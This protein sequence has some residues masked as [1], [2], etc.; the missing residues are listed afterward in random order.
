MSLN[1]FDKRWIQSDK[2]P[3]GVTLPMLKLNEQQFVFTSYEDDWHGLYVY[4]VHLGKYDKFFEYPKKMEIEHYLAYDA[5]Q[6]KLYCVG[7]NGPMYIIDINSGEFMECK[8]IDCYN[9]RLSANSQ[10]HLVGGVWS[11]KHWIW[12]DENYN[13]CQIQEIK[14]DQDLGQIV[15]LSLVYIPKKGIIIMII[16]YA[17]K[18]LNDVH[19]FNIKSRQWKKVAQLPFFHE[20]TPVLTSDER[21]II[22]RDYAS[23][24]IYALE[25]DTYLLYLSRISTPCRRTCFMTRTGGQKDEMLVFGWIKSL[26]A[27]TGYKHMKEPSYDLKKL[28]SVWYSQEEVHWYNDCYGQH[29]TIQVNQLV[30]SLVALQKEI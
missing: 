30:S 12:D 15:D 7:I 22:M 27:S 9:G 13:F 25:M 20:E 28:I 19:Q 8:E 6:N 3:H 18:G 23:N 14:H 5:S 17:F 1:K 16:G 21:Y 29:M 11:S 4:Y 26:F 24:R 10:I 2:M